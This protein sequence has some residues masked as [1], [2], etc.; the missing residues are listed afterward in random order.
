MASITTKAITMKE[1]LKRPVRP[2]RSST[3]PQHRRQIPRPARPPR[4]LG[5]GEARRGSSSAAT[6]A[7]TTGLALS[8]LISWANLVRDLPDRA[9]ILRRSTKTLQNPPTKTAQALKNNSPTT[10]TQLKQ[11]WAPTALKKQ[12]DPDEPGPPCPCDP[13]R[14][15][16][17]W[18]MNHRTRHRQNWPTTFGRA[19]GGRGSTRPDHSLVRPIS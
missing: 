4:V 17:I 18:P 11:P 16:R 10:D 7:G 8:A 2:V 19:P 15:K 9:Q 1:W 3:G 6:A 12:P 14:R 13:G 5:A